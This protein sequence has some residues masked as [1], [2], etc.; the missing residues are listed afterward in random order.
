M[1]KKCENKKFKQSFISSLLTDVSLMDHNEFENLFFKNKIQALDVKI[2]ENDIKDEELLF[3]PFPK[4]NLSVSVPK[5]TI[6]EIST[7]VL[8]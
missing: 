8:E 2:I 1:E 6:K 7:L 4:K 5:N 3:F